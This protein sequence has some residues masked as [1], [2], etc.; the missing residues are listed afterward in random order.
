[1]GMMMPMTLFMASVLGS[2]ECMSSKHALATSMARSLFLW[3]AP[4]A[5]FMSSSMAP[6]VGVQTTDKN[7]FGKKY[8]PCRLQEPRW[9]H[10]KAWRMPGPPGRVRFLKSTAAV[11]KNRAKEGPFL[12]FGGF[13]MVPNRLLFRCG[14]LCPGRAGP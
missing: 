3:S 13:L 8:G 9:V 2:G 7:I 14:I 11:F 10:S 4:R 1:M 6:Y 12:D 5:S